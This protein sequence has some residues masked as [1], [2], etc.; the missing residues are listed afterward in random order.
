MRGDAAVLSG[1]L[2]IRPEIFAGCLAG[3]SRSGAVFGREICDLSFSAIPVS[4]AG[5]A[6]FRRG[7]RSAEE[8]GPIIRLKKNNRMTITRR[9][10]EARSIIVRRG[11]FPLPFSG[12][13]PRMD[14]VDVP[15]VSSPGEERAAGVRTG[16]FSASPFCLAPSFFFGRGDADDPE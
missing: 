13:F 14:D 11:G 9:R 2:G 7:S 10:V 3:S 5:A 15:E 1:D 12:K 6:V 16:V 4:T 8:E